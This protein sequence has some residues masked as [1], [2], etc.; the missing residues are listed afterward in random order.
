MSR[1]DDLIRA[2]RAEESEAIPNERIWNAIEARLLHGFPPA[3]VEGVSWLGKVMPGK[4]VLGLAFVMSGGFLGGWLLAPAAEPPGV[5][6][7]GARLP[8]LE[9]AQRSE[10]DELALERLRP[11]DPPAGPPSAIPEQAPSA[12]ASEPRS[13]SKPRDE[14]A[15]PTQKRLRRQAGAREEQPLARTLSHDAVEGLSSRNDIRAELRLVEEI[16]AALK[17]GDM[18]TLLEKADK[19]ARDFGGSGQLI[20]ER[21]VHTI[22]ALCAL[23]RVNEAKQT[24]K[25]LLT[26]WPSSTQARRARASCAGQ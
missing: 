23:G 24:L 21:L 15:R 26:G 11:T 1:L 2:A 20:E 9:T 12:E 7:I 13:V 6:Q 18:E 19:H 22:E 16:E 10:A 17:R 5:E 4:W 14:T 3:S 8:A 25:E